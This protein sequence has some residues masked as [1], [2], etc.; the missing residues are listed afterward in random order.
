LKRLAYLTACF[1]FMITMP[2]RAQWFRDMADE[3]Y[4]SDIDP[5]TYVAWGDINDDGYDDL[6]VSNGMASPIF[7]RFRLFKNTA[8]DHFE[9]I[10]YTCGISLDYDCSCAIFGDYDND[11]W[12]LIGVTPLLLFASLFADEKKISLHL[13]MMAVGLGLLGM[14]IHATVIKSGYWFRE[15]FAYHSFRLFQSILKRQVRKFRNKF[16]QA[17]DQIRLAYPVYK[18][19]LLE[20]RRSRPADSS[21]QYVLPHDTVKAVVI[22]FKPDDNDGLELST[23]EEPPLLGD[24]NDPGAHAHEN[25]NQGPDDMAILGREVKL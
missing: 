6:L 9:E 23:A 11:G 20:V 5:T 8:G 17:A 4:V 2:G 18:V 22:L 16:E 12:L 3:L 24:P 19:A 21:I 15:S 7:H 1:V 10:T 14:V 13:A 25:D